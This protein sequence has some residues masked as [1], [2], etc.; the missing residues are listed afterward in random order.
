VKWRGRERRF[1]VLMAGIGAGSLTA[2]L[3]GWFG[4]LPTFMGAGTLVL[5]ILAVT[6]IWTP[7][8]VHVI[9]LPFAVL[10]FGFAVVLVPGGVYFQT[11][12]EMCGAV[13]ILLLVGW[14]VIVAGMVFMV[15][16]ERRLRREKGTDPFQ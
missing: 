14:A 11:D 15:R 5:S 3:L 12:H 13:P 16:R 9:E 8:R 7:S 10:M 2:A 1:T 6:R 4:W